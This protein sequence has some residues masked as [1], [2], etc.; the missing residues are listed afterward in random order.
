MKKYLKTLLASVAIIFASNAMAYD[1]GLI[2]NVCKKPKFTSF[3]LA[4]YTAATKTEVLPA[5]EFSFV[6]SNWIDPTTLE[7]TAKKK[8]LDFTITD[9]NSFFL[10][11][12]KLPAE[13]VGQFVRL[14][15]IVNARLG[16]KGLDGWLVKVAAK[17]VEAKPVEATP[18]EA[19]PAE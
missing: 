11:H 10:V 2:E 14:D 8:K 1:P 17:P 4:E 12:A 15:A 16:C 7:L 6:V 19:K 18:A 3:S 9:K 13:Y 5:S